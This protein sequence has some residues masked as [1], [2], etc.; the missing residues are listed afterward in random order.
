MTNEV[1]ENILNYIL[2]GKAC[3]CIYQESKGTSRGGKAWY[4][5]TSEDGN[6]FF[7][8]EL[9]NQ[10]EEYLGYFFISDLSTIKTLRI[11][12]KKPKVDDPNKDAK[13]LVAVIRHLFRTDELPGEGIVHIISDGKCSICGRRLTDFKSIPLGI[14]PTCLEKMR[15]R[16]F[17]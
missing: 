7:V 15:R 4:S 3:F 9:I 2:G 16:G 1:T 17:K 8:H 12:R 5:V 14:G 6:I 10:K 11:G 13:P